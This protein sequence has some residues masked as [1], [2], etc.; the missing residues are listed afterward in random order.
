M[1][2]LL[3]IDLGGTNCRCGLIDLSNSTGVLRHEAVYENIGFSGIEETVAHYLDEHKVQADYL[4]MAVAGVVEGDVAELTNL[5]WRVDGSVVQKRFNLSKVW[6]LND[7]MALAEAVPALGPSDLHVVCSGEAKERETIGVVA[8]GTGLGQGYL[9]YHRGEYLARGSEGGH[10]T[11]APMD[12]NELDLARWLMEQGADLSIERLC[13]GTGLDTLYAYHSNK[14][15]V[16]PAEWVRQRIASVNNLAPTIVE[17]ATAAEP[18]PLC[19]EVI[20]SFLRLLG[21][22]SGNLALKIYARGGMYIGGG[23]LLHLLGRISFQPFVEAFHS[24]GKM[25]DLLRRIPVYLI[26]RE[27]VNLYGVVAY[28]KKRIG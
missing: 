4:C 2:S 22:E 10:S 6:L 19:A 15:T 17:G 5:A 25:S 13:S 12:V 8:P 3:A 1:S 23:V 20:N 28:A 27:H 14:G 18:C 9:V 24:K 11:F 21:G 16:E 26:T 7:M